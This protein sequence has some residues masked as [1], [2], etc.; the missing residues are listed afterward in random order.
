MLARYFGMIA[1]LISQALMPGQVTPAATRG[2]LASGRKASSCGTVRGIWGG[3]LRLQRGPIHISLSGSGGQV[4][5]TWDFPLYLAESEAIKRHNRRACACVRAFASVCAR[6]RIL[7]YAPVNQWNRL[8][9]CY[10]RACL[11]ACLLDC[12]LACFLS[13]FLSCFLCFFLFFFL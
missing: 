13:F 3:W 10:V 9:Y 11:R 6:V 2:S 1:L 7:F 8:E 4:C 5:E 12:L